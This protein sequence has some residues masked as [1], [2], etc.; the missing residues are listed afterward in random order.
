MELLEKAWVM[1]CLPGL[2]LE[3]EHP[4]LYGALICVLVLILLSWE[5]NDY[6]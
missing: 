5:G 4:K 2:W 6:R 3:R 1:L